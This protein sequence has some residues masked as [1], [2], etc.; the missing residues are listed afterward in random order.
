MGYSKD[1]VKVNDVSFYDSMN[2]IAVGN[3][4]E[5]LKTND[6]GKDWTNISS[7]T[8]FLPLMD[9]KFIDENIGT[10]IGM[11]NYGYTSLIMNTIDGGRNWDSNIFPYSEI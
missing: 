2:G 11:A 9:I 3:N 1:S 10:A 6:G 5:I 8:D 4:G 7:G